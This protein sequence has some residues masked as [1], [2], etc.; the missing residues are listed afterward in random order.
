M[1]E[2][3]LTEKKRNAFFQEFVIYLSTI[4]IRSPKLSKDFVLRPDKAFRRFRAQ[5][6]LITQ[7]DISQMCRFMSQ[8][9]QPQNHVFGV[10]ER[11]IFRTNQ[12]ETKASS[13]L[14]SFLKFCVFSLP[15]WPFDYLRTSKSLDRHFQNTLSLSISRF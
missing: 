15:A 8:F 10:S 12:V 3:I 6:L 2:C 14:S 1:L 13:Y 7:L 5:N 9:F 11:H 4:G